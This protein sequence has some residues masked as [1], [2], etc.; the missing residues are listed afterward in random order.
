MMLMTTMAMAMTQVNLWQC[1]QLSVT[2]QDSRD[3]QTLLEAL[4]ESSESI[5]VGTL[6][7]SVEFGST[8]DHFRVECAL[9]YTGK[10]TCSI[11]YQDYTATPDS[12]EGRPTEFQLAPF[13]SYQL[14]KKI[15]LGQPLSFATRDGVFSLQC[16]A[17]RIP[18]DASCKI[19]LKK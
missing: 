17:T 4:P 8:L 5:D 2:L 18:T 12:C 7:R 13:L 19:V 16:Q 10:S 9:N 6:F 3:A 14:G 15:Q 1:N 11:V